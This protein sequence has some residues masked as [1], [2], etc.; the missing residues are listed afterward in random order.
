MRGNEPTSGK[1]VNAG[2]S[3]L[4]VLDPLSGK[5]LYLAFKFTCFRK[6]L[7]VSCQKLRSI[8]SDRIFGEHGSCCWVGGWWVSGGWV[9]Q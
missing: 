5:C 7:F 9:G 4:P 2:S 8:V 1:P 6:R 3:V